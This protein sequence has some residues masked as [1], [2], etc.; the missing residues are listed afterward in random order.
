[1]SFSLRNPQLAKELRHL[2]LPWIGAVAAGSLLAVRPLVEGEGLETLLMAIVLYGFFGGLALV[3]VVSFGGEF[4]EHT[5]ALLLTQPV[6]RSQL[7]KKKLLLVIIA[8]VAALLVEGLV[9]A[10]VSSWYS[11]SE[12]WDALL[13]T[14]SVQGLGLAAVFILATVC[15]CGYWTLVAGSIIGGLV[16]TIAIQVITAELVALVW[17]RVSNNPEPFGNSGLFPALI[18]AGAIYSMLFL[19]LGRRKFLNYEV[20]ATRFSESALREN[21]LQTK[22]AAWFGLVSTPGNKFLNFAR[23]ELMLLTPAVQ[24]AAFFTISWLVVLV[25][26]WQ[27]HLAYLF[28]IFTCLYAPIT[29][30]LAGCLSLGEEKVLGIDEAQLT[31]PLS[32]TLQWLLK[33]V[34]G[35]FGAALLSL[36]LP[37]LLFWGTGLVVD[38]SQSGL[39]GQNDNGKWQLVCICGLAF[40]LSFW[41]AAHVANTVRAAITTV[42]GII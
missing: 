29:C 4:Q 31:L 21:G 16:F 17:A 36:G 24:L 28:D 40:I 27:Q 3:A 37:L 39:V 2:R 14:F 6:P 10:T 18:I 42:V 35:A 5:W 8:V 15:S 25:I 7:W 9:L 38:L 23:K 41:A 33:L 20:R 19:W 22:I 13:R 1:M 26:Q 34:V 32:P 12:L 11:G 30:L